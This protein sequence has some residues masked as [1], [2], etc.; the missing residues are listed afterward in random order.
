MAD[1]I[2]L[3][4]RPA[5]QMPGEQRDLVDDLFPEQLP[6]DFSLAELVKLVLDC[7][8]YYEG[9]AK[10]LEQQHQQLHEIMERLAALETQGA[11]DG[12]EHTDLGS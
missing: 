3:L 2:K 5:P 6:A 4:G 1:R 11:V 12:G 7:H 10:V 8:R 9:L